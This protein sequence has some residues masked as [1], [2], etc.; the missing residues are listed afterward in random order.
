MIGK[1]NFHLHSFFFFFLFFQLNIAAHGQSTIDSLNMALDTLE[2]IEKID[3]LNKIGKYY[4]RNNAVKTIEISNSVILEAKNK[5]YTEGLKVAYYNLGVAY[6][7]L[8]ELEKSLGAY[9]EAIAYSDT[10][11]DQIFLVKIYNN[12]GA[13]Y[14]ELKEPEKT[15]SYY[16]K[17]IDILRKHENNEQMAIILLNIA[18]EFAEGENTDSALFYMDEAYRNALKPG[19]KDKSLPILI[20][21]NKAELY[22]LRGEYNKAY[23]TVNLALQRIDST[24]DNYTKSG[25]Y[26]V[27]GR[28]YNI[29]GKHDKSINAIK[30]SIALAKETGSPGKQMQGHEI[31]ADVYKGM[32]KNKLALLEYEKYN[33]LKDSTLTSEKNRQILEIEAKYKSEKQQKEIELLKNEKALKESELSRSK[34]QS[35]LFG[36]LAVLVLIV[37][38]FIYKAFRFKLKANNELS[39]INSILVESEAKLMELN[40]MKDNLIRIIGHDL[41]GPLGSVIGFAELLT[42]SKFD[43]QP[44]KIKKFSDLIFSTSQS[45]NQLLENILFWAKLQQGGYEIKP[46]TFNVKEAV[47]QGAI[48]YEAIAE[49]K[50]IEVVLD[51][52]DNVSA[53]G[54]RFTCSIVVGNL[55][56]NALKFSHKKSTINIHVA[57]VNGEIQIAVEDKGIGI[58]DE[59]R[60]GLFDNNRFVTRQGTGNESGTGFGLKIC[61]QFVELNNG[62]IWIDSV[63]GKGSTFYFTYPKG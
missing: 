50:N 21:I 8:M 31:L 28:V 51:V 40:S 46:E 61:R 37:F 25:A 17:G 44:E 16:K 1:T 55:I 45:I 18:I 33:V 60:K 34:I 54:D 38:L 22:I 56:N 43:S 24:T 13:L 29:L 2:G 23:N 59:V 19:V 4:N 52:E 48:P 32:G 7:Y 3:Q 6:Y 63:P 20:P 26:L 14:G 42:M 36:T 47:I 12:I 15:I 57:A 27:L 35:Y 39:K 30:E 53:Y 49:N 10:S 9:Q 11:L 41:K 62:K 58:E 5:N